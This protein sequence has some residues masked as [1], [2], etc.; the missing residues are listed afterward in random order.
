[1]HSEPD[2]PASPSPSSAAQ[3][4]PALA[5]K[6][7]LPSSSTGRSRK[8]ERAVMKIEAI[9]ALSTAGFHKSIARTLVDGALA[10]APE[11]VTLE[12]LLVTALQRS[13]TS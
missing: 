13:R 10:T 8:Y 5:S 7:P 12:A 4:A 6:S 9:Q 1:M 3:V 11:D 2:N